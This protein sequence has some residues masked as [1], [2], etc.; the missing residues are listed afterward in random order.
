M[1]HLQARRAAQVEDGTRD[2]MWCLGIGAPTT[3]TRA[4]AAS[5]ED[6]NM[7]STLSWSF[8]LGLVER[9]SECSGVFLSWKIEL[10]HI[11]GCRDHAMWSCD[12]SSLIFT[13][14]RRVSGTDC[15]PPTGCWL[16]IMC[17]NCERPESFE[18][19]KSNRTGADPPARCFHARRSSRLDSQTNLHA[20]KRKTTPSSLSIKFF[21]RP[22]G[23]V[24][25]SS[26]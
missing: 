12:W 11:P 6:E 25:T 15:K 10:W 7:R 3:I 26:R 13:S 14:F 5:G 2:P 24:S 20:N 4:D 22:V 1:A 23:G 9:T 8:A 19:D 21:G 18:I 16:S 17:I